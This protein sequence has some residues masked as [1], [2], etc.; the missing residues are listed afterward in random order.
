LTATF[1]GLLCRL[2]TVIRLTRKRIKRN[3]NDDRCALT[4]TIV[5][6]FL[7]KNPQATQVETAKAIGKSRRAVQDAVAAL[8]DKGLLNHDGARKNGQWIV[9]Q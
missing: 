4:E 6:D 7:R 2:T 3:K 5:F 1:F 8:K 9:K